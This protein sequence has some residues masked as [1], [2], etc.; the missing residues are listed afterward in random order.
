MATTRLTIGEFS[1][2][3]HLSVKTLRHCHDVG[4]LVP[5]AIDGETGYRFCGTD[6]VTAA[7]VIR[8]RRD[9]GMPLDGIRSVLLAPDLAARNRQIA[10]RL[11]RMERQLA[12]TQAAVSGLRALL[13]GTGPRPAVEFRTIPGRRG[14]PH[15]GALGTVVA[16]RAIGVDGPIREYYPDGFSGAAPHRTEICWPVFRTGQPA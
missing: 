3:T 16:E 9:L 15:Y 10:E 7:Q 2:M 11:E 13:G 4:V 5:A 8:R 6:Q 14:R 1:R 12:Q